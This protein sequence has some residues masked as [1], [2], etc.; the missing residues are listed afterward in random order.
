MPLVEGIGRDLLVLHTLEI[1]LS[2]MV[3]QDATGVGVRETDLPTY[4]GIRT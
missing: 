4:E 2:E 1:T 3:Q